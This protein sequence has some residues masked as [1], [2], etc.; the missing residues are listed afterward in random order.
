M[1]PDVF[2]PVPA[3]SERNYGKWR[4]NKRL[5]GLRVLFCFSQNLIV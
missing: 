4:L 3:V 1:L 2:M 5:F